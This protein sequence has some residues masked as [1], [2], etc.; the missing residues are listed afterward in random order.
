MVT[1]ACPIPVS[2]R[3]LAVMLAGS[4]V[5]PAMSHA[6]QFPVEEPTNIASSGENEALGEIVVTAQKRSEPLQRV[7]L[8]AAVVGGELIAQQGIASL[9]DLTATTPAVRL[10]KGTTTNRQ[11]I[12]GVGSGDNAGFEQSVG[13][14]IDDIYHGRART[15]EASLFD[16]A[17]V[18]VLKGPQ[19]TY[20]GNNAIAGALN[21]VTRDP[22]TVIAG[23]VRA[24]YNSTFDM[25]TLEGAIDLPASDTLA[26]RVAGIV[27]R[28]DGWIDD[29]GLGHRVPRTRNGGIRGTLLWKPTSDFTARI[30]AQYM[31]ER[32]D[33]GLPIVRQGCPP[34]PVFGAPAGFC[35]AAIASGAAPYSAF[36]ERNSG[37]GQASHLHQQDYVATLTLDRGAFA[38]TSVTGYVRYD[39]GLTVDVDTSPADLLS[40]GSPERFHQFSQELRITSDQSR[41]IEYLA[42]VYYQ[43]GRLRVRNTLAYNFLTPRIASAP[44]FAALLPF[45][46]FA[47]SSAFDQ[48][49]SNYS[50]FGAVT[51]KISPAVRATGSLRYT[52]VEKDFDR[53]VSVGTST[54]IGTEPTPFPGGVAALG[55]AFAQGAGLA[56]VGTTSLS[57][58]DD[59]LSSSLSLQYDPSQT[60]ML[61]AR[62]DRGFKAGGFNGAD[63]S[64]APDLLPFAPEK[65]DAFEIG[66]K[67]RLFDNRATLNIALFRSKYRDLQLAGIVPSTTGAYINRV[68]NAGGAI[69]QG[70]EAEASIRINSMLRTSLSAAYLDAHYTRYANAT[71]TAQQTLQGRVVQDL[72]GAR[73]PFS[74]KLSGSWTVSLAFPL[75]DDLTLRVDNQLYASGGIFLNFNNDPFVRQPR[76]AREDLTV[77]LASVHGWEFSV[78]GKNLTNHVIRSYG[79]AIATSLGS[80]V[81]MTEPSRNVA[82][83]LRYMF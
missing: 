39:Y 51:W 49:E 73:T 8:S 40:V 66:A 46:P 7:P 20:F 67:T 56:R 78:V 14:F 79:A 53:T 17:R 74:P 70:V 68:Q 5:V 36:F 38:L 50:G 75:T 2:K 33:G 52:K 15:S 32:Q 18:E 26:V 30:K 42:G 11:F 1:Q 3:F 6:A 9:Q 81:F 24:A 82:F 72:S 41:P 4:A 80:Y 76:Y 43:R 48:H 54:G 10:A 60:M 57:R 31:T 64:S 45:T 37:A 21:I 19:T 12:R 65:V 28:G 13:T 62:Y 83:Q 71:P 77:T 27:S 69:T 16:V 25:P 22:G 34:A 55:A 29:I 47:V 59:K 23:Q 35:A 61:Y 58:T 63:F 44:A